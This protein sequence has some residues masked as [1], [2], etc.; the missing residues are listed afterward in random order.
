MHTLCAQP[1]WWQHPTSSAA[2]SLGDQLMA[3]RGRRAWCLHTWQ[4]GDRGLA[5][6]RPRGCQL[7]STWLYNLTL[8]SVIYY[9]HK[10]GKGRN[11]RSPQWK[12]CTVGL[13][14]Q[15]CQFWSQDL[16]CV[17][18]NCYQNSLI[19]LLQSA[20]VEKAVDWGRRKETSCASCCSGAANP[21]R[22][23]SLCNA[24]EQL[25]PLEPADLWLD[26]GVMECIWIY[27][28]LAEV[29]AWKCS[30]PF[31]SSLTSVVRGLSNWCGLVVI[32]QKRW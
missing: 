19:W 6:P 12:V 21:R 29:R 26:S 18:W 4:A 23:H 32:G 7:Q 15:S 16:P 28:F 9:Q 2:G 14:C 30:H 22:H 8:I 5:V 11:G 25:L 10:L 13:L 24:E 17:Q 31:L 20:G 27:F 3:A 1:A